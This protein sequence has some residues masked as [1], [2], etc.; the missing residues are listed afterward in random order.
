MENKVLNPDAWKLIRQFPKVSLTEQQKIYLSEVYDLSN[1]QKSIK[2]LLLNNNCVAVDING[3]S[4]LYNGQVKAL[5]DMLVY[6]IM[7]ESN[8][9]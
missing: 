2:E 7:N 4:Y 6:D 1:A 8:M 9:E 3:K 5:I